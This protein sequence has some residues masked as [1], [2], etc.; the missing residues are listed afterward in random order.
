MS[1]D[2]VECM[3]CSDNVVR[4]GLTQKHRD[5]DTLCEMLTY[6]MQSAEQTKFTP[7]KHPTVPNALVYDPPTPEFTVVRINIPTGTKELC[8]PSVA[9]QMSVYMCMCVCVC[10]CVDFCFIGK[11]TAMG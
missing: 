4:A 3:A 2:I 10:V 9:G 5:K 1:I 8:I 11:L 6:N 7:R